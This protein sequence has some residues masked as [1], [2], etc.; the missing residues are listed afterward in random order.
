VWVVRDE[1]PVRVDVV[2][3]KIIDDLVVVTG[4]LTA[5]ELVQTTRESTQNM[6]ALFGAGD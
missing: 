4:N 6:P 2:G 5:G 1:V 3:G